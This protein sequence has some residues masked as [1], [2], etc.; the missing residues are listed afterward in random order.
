MVFATCGPNEAMVVS[1][2]CK[3]RP[4]MIPGGSV[5]VWPFIEQLQRISLNVMK[6][7]VASLD[8]CT[9]EGVAISCM[10]IAQIKIQG[11]SQEMLAA[12]CMQFLGKSPKQ[13][14]KIV[15]E[16]LEG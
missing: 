9:L 12:A 15:L 3:S 4:V 6:L 10:G 2:C 14:S 8:V 16:T 1:G 7:Q 11:Q 5:W 13:I